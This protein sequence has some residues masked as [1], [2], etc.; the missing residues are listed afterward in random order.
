MVKATHTVATRQPIPPVTTENGAP[1]QFATA[2]ASSSPSCGPPMKNTMLTPVMRPR[3]R[4]G[5][6]S[7]RMTF[8]MTMLTVSVAPVSARHAKVSQ[9]DREIPNTSV[10]SP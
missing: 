2:P 4:S 1:N 5:V 3:S 7:W 8:R 9:N 10:A 6:S